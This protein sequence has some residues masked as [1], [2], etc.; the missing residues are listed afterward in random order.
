M[1]QSKAPHRGLAVPSGRLSRLARF[2]SM[3]SG[4]A[5]SIAVNGARQVIEGRRPVMGELLLTPANAARITHQL[6]QMRGAAMK[7]GQ[8]LSMEAGDILP[9]E[10]AEIL[11]RLRSDAHPM[12]SRQLKAVLEA[13][14]GPRFMRRFARFDVQPIAAASIGQ[15]HRAQTKDGRDLAIKVQYPGVRDSIDSD[16]RN[17]AALI[18]MSGLVPSGLDIAP[19]LEEATRQLHEEAD[20]AREGQYL[21]RFGAL[22]ADEPDY[23]VPT[24]AEDFSTER[25]LAMSYQAGVPV[26][27]LETAPQDVRDRVVSSLVQ[28]MLRELFEHR[29]MQT[30]PN[31]ANY[32]YDEAS[33]R[34]VLLD[35]GAARELLSETAERYRALMRAGLSGDN[36]GLECA[37]EAIGFVS[38]A[39]SERQRQAIFEMIGLALT[40]LRSD[41]VF[42][43]GTTPIVEELRDRGMAMAADREV[44]HVPPIDTLFVQ[45]KIAGV[46]LLARR[47]RARVPVR[48]LLEPFARA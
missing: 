45:R 42:D 5:G 36:K 32:L 12:P 19:L 37:A 2:G 40:P 8:L 46:F 18:R 21:A 3:A 10:M 9:P 33:G 44:S 20:Y 31:F 23:I 41:A 30:D 1:S 26:E 47:L 13:E 25:L 14:W 29:L 4:I 24:I 28:L 35:F 7:V 17:V 39:T 38:P 22:L 6:A 15:V 16:V 43:F 11:A 48:H 34:L 27:S